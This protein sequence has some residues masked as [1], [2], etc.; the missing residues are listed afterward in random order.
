MQIDDLSVAVVHG[1]LTDQ[2]VQKHTLMG[3][4]RFFGG[5]PVLVLE[6][7]GFELTV[8]QKWIE[9][10]CLHFTFHNLFPLNHNNLDSRFPGSDCAQHYQIR[11]DCQRRPNFKFSPFGFSGS[12]L[13]LKPD[14]ASRFITRISF[15]RAD[16]R[17]FLEWMKIENLSNFPQQRMVSS[18]NQNQYLLNCSSEFH[19]N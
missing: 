13:G 8:S 2:T 16:R 5:W 3:Y 15:E 17:D 18:E 19:E 4:K 9:M 14:I 10:R 7:C 1:I 11:I 12:D 6:K